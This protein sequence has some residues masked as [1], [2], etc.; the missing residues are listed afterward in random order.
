MSSSVR[1]LEHRD[2][3]RASALA[4]EVFRFAY[5]QAYS[6]RD[7]FE[8]Y[9]RAVFHPEAWAKSLRKDCIECLVAETDD[10]LAGFLKLA[11]TP[12]PANV[13]C[14]NAAEIAKLYVREE[15][16]GAGVARPLMERAIAT[17]RQAGF[18]AVWLTVWEHNP[19]ARAFYR[20]HGLE[21][22]GDI[23]I[24]MNGVPFRDYVMWKSIV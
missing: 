9:V 18:A 23:V 12:T 21:T 11:T 7:A 19:R 17:A 24:P 3:E 6:D 15:F 5:Q 20:K 2:N 16:H 4:A 10:E 13:P 8:A 1:P 14:A 22:V